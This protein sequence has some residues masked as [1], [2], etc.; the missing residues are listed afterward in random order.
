[1]TM[2][3]WSQ[4]CMHRFKPIK[5]HYQDIELETAIIDVAAGNMTSDE[6]AYWF[7]QHT[8]AKS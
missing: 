7:H 8:D 6:L 3:F 1:M 4:L 2:A 5:L